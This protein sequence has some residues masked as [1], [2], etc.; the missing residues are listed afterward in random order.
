VR[1]ELVHDSECDVAVRGG[2]D[3]VPLVSQPERDEVGDALLVVDDED[4]S[5]PTHCFEYMSRFATALPR[6]DLESHFSAHSQQPK[7]LP[8]QPI[9]LGR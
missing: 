5:R 4:A 8:E 3:V 2:P 7:A 1:L 9:T 6:D